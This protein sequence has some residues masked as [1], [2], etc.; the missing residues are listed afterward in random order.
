MDLTTRHVINND[1]NT[2][3]PECHGKASKTNCRIYDRFVIAKIQNGQ[4]LK[5]VPNNKKLYLATDT[6]SQV[7]FSQACDTSRVNGVIQK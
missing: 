5:H 7:T 3:V 1:R 4:S 6:C 2:S